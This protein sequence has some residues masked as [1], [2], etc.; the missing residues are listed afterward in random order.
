MLSLPDFRE[1]HLVISFAREGQ[2]VSFKN[3][4]LIITEKNGDVVVQTTCHKLFSLWII[5][6]TTITSGLLERSKKFGFSIFMLSY[7]NRQY[8]S[9]NSAVEGNFLLRHK[10]YSYNNLE[11]ARYLVE[12]KIA[13]QR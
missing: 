8:G 12:T 13:N 7:S 3:D 9:W 4:N 11:L 10:Q 6:S 2:K 1:K 5:G